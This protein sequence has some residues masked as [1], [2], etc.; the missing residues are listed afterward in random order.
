MI[1][2][3][4]PFVEVAKVPSVLGL[5]RGVELLLKKFVFVNPAEKWMVYYLVRSVGTETSPLV[6]VQ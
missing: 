2:I 4:Q 5:V 3:N 1:F 6:L